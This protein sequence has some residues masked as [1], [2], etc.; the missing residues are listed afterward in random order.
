MFRVPHDSHTPSRGFRGTML[1]PYILQVRSHTTL[2][3][4]SPD[5]DFYVLE[6]R[7]CKFCKS[8]KTNLCGKGLCYIPVCSF[9][10]THYI[11]IVRATQGQGLMPD[12]TSRFSINGQKIFHFVCEFVCR[13][14]LS[15]EDLHRPVMRWESQRS[16][17]IQSLQTSRWS[18]SIKRP[19]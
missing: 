6:C 10:K 9:S 15:Q 11:H 2:P 12:K 19:R 4:I 13:S 16:L 17:N 3:L 8:G 18:P 7:E 5:P 1:F 14:F